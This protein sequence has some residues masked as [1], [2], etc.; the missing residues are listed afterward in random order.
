MAIRFLLPVLVVFYGAAFAEKDTS[1]YTLSGGYSGLGWNA[2]FHWDEIT[3]FGEENNFLF[4]LGLGFGLVEKGII[5][6]SG[7][8]QL[9]M[10]LPDNPQFAVVGGMNS[11]I[12]IEDFEFVPYIG[13]NWNGWV[14]TLGYSLCTKGED[15][16]LSF[17]TGYIFKR[18]RDIPEAKENNIEKPATTESSSSSYFRP[19]I[20]L[21][22]PVY[23]SEIDFFDDS[24]PYIAAGAGLF[25]RIGPE[26]LYFTTGAYAKL[27][28]L[29]KEVTKDLGLFG[30]NTATLPL[31]NIEWD[32]LFV[33]VP[34]LLS[35]G[36]G[37]IR[38]TGGALLDFYATSEIFVE[39]VF[40]EQVLSVSDASEIEE[41]FNEIPFGNMY[42]VLGLD[43]DIVRH[44]GIGV[45]FLIWNST[46]DEPE[47]YG[48]I[49]EPSHYQTR[50]STY[51]VF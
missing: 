12:G 20:E 8:L 46:F 31:L 21:N 48:A 42:W 4:I 41:K 22:Y 10:L 27:D 23:R 32:R 26:Y 45:K 37:Q 14:S 30:I 7:D 43:I 25:F 6:G 19:G 38:F 34:L 44:W 11:K 50:V 29:Q 49:F 39:E 33:E 47:L 2:V 9:Q 15:C 1:Y 18:I 16:G 24:F 28:I 5:A 3:S 35:F 40:G 36:S 51:F 13:L 17:S